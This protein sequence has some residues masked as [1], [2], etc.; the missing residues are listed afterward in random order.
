MSVRMAAAS[1]RAPQAWAEVSQGASA[2][3]EGAQKV[4][5]TAVLQQIRALI[6]MSQTSIAIDV[7]D[8][9]IDI[10]YIDKP[11]LDAEDWTAACEPMQ[12]DDYSERGDS[13]SRGG[14]Q[15][16]KELGFFS[17]RLLPRRFESNLNALRGAWK[18]G[19]GTN[20]NAAKKQAGL[21][22]VCPS[23]DSADL[24]D[25][26]E[27]VSKPGVFIF[28]DE[29]ESD[30]NVFNLMKAYAADYPCGEAEGEEPSVRRRR[31]G[32]SIGEHCFLF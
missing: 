20:K 5:T 11:L 16:A 32:L 14:K 3:S 31:R 30:D 7:L 2:S 19:A 10:D 6:L 15:H 23:S 25:P 13:A 21:F 4:S 26:R 8:N 18:K 17:R 27:V 28:Y 22:A 9:L 29:D 12:S 24:N 1:T